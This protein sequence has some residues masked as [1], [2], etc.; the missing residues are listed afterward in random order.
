MTK[1]GSP[2]EGNGF[3]LPEAAPHMLRATFPTT[4]PVPAST[5][6]RQGLGSAS[7]RQVVAATATTARE[8]IATKPV[9]R[10]PPGRS[11]QVRTRPVPTTH[12]RHQVFLVTGALIVNS[13]P[14]LL[15]GGRRA[16][17]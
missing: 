5:N 11:A 1:R 10:A 14:Q 9:P 7:R 3:V 6:H 4:K 2:G 13:D 17:D 16:V 8:A 12:N 15:P